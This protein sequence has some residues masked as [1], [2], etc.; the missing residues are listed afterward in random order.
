MDSKQLCLEMINAAE[1]LL[2]TLHFGC[3]VFFYLYLFSVAVNNVSTIIL[4]GIPAWAVYIPLYLCMYKLY[5]LFWPLIKNVY[6]RPYLIGEEDE[7]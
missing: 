4:Y 1:I 2:D 3:I 6:V 5:L 7:N